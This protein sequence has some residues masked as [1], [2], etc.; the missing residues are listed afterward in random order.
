MKGYRLQGSG[1][2]RRFLQRN[3]VSLASRGVPRD[4]AERRPWARKPWVQ[5][6]LESK[7]GSEEPGVVMAKALTVL[8]QILGL[9]HRCL[10]SEGLLGDCS[11]AERALRAQQHFPGA[12]GARSLGRVAGGL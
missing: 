2:N 11:S 6:F 3:C 5:R 4:W 10:G 12:T 1:R 8:C 7:A 9:F